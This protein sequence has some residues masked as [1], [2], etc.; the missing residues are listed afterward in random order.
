MRLDDDRKGL[1]SSSAVSQAIH[2]S[3]LV[4]RRH[5]LRGLNNRR[6]LLVT[7][8]IAETCS[9]FPLFL[10]CALR[11]D[12]CRDGLASTITR[13]SAYIL[14]HLFKTTFNYC[15]L[16]TSI[17]FFGFSCMNWEDPHL[18][19]DFTARNLSEHSVCHDPELHF[20]YNKYLPF[21]NMSTW[22]SLSL[23]RVPGY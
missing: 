19:L 9:A 20:T 11:I 22:K 8:S 18:S 2:A 7:P 10:T 3:L 4:L 13:I 12:Q 23:F 21:I 1:P 6:S 15:Y 14:H 16:F 5:Q 17:F